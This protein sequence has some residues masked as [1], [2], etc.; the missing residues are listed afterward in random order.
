M[1]K[2]PVKY[3]S[4]RDNYRDASRTCFS[5]SCAMALEYLKPE[6]I[7]NDDDYVQTVFSIGDSTEAWVQVKALSRYGISAKF[8]Q[9]MTNSRM[10]ALLDDGIPVPCGILHHGPSYHPSGG[11]HW[12]L[13]T[14]Y[15][16]DRN[17][18]GGG[19]WLVNDP[20]GEIDHASGS[21][22]TTNGEQL[23]YSFG[24][25]DSR[26]T[27]DGSDD[28][29]SIVIDRKHAKPLQEPLQE[30]Q[31][32][33]EETLAPKKDL[34]SKTTL[35]FIWDCH[36]N[37]IYD[38]EVVEMNKCLHKF[39]I[40]TT[41]RL[42]HFLSQTAHESGGGRYKKELSSGWAYEFR[43]DLGNYYTGDG[44]KYK[45]AGYIQLT[46]RANYQRFCDYIG[47]PRVM[48]GVDYVADT[49]PFSSAGYW[50]KSNGMN[51]LCDSGASIEQVTLRVNGGYN[52]LE[53][54]K[55]YYKRCTWVIG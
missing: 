12:I 27:V 41:E 25:M 35:A 38:F 28:G 32:T 9:N 31:E 14:G 5:S 23:R 18:P 17:Y 45:G 3:W 4:Q 36:P 26:W 20:W 53:D 46:G 47:D 19:Y 30:L 22:V 13:V 15:V 49:Y 37:L 10:K 29:W 6:A 39:E 33:Q 50:W 24:L 21:Y 42:R 52:G 40:N 51:S 54:R 11:G 8:V 34:I 43:E 44:P 55:H 2:L 7:V 48:E 1:I 16:D